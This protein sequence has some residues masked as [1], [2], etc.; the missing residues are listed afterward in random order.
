MSREII[1]LGGGSWGTAAS[2]VLVENGHSVTL[3]FR[4][5]SKAKNVQKTRLNQ[6]Y[7]PD[8]VL[9]EKMVISS[10]IDSN[11]PSADMVVLAVPTQKI[12]ELLNKF[13]N[14]IQPHTILVNLSKGLEKDSLLRISQVCDEIL[15][16]NKYVVLSG[17]SHAEEVA[18]KMPTTVVAASLDEEASKTTQ[19]IFMND[20]FRVYTNSDVTGVEIGGALKN[21]IALAAGISDGLGFG[22]NTKAALINRG[23]F[24]ISRLAEKMG[25]DKLTFMGL[26]GIGDLIVTCTSMHSRNRR[27]GILIGKGYTREEAAE[28][29]GMVVEGILTTHAAYHLAKKMAVEMPIVN[30]LYAIL[31]L[32]EK[33]ADTVEKLMKRDKKDELND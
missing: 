32:G 14:F 2:K 4:D 31:F 15:P 28:A 1:V 19:D 5:D 12:R 24:E 10:C 27:A 33:A 25:A 17:P 30:E 29:V 9:P 26:S 7:L 11:L 6:H 21:V 20:Y 18:L 23:I 22:D 3:W 8:V 16:N 13:K